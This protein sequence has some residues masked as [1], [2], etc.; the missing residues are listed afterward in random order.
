MTNSEKLDNVNFE[1]EF[2]AE[3]AEKK[4]EMLQKEWEA[5]YQ[6]ALE[7]ERNE[8]AEYV[9]NTDISSTRSRV[10]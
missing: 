1:K 5:N 10:K 7:N 9:G 8:H 4:L 6:F 2:K 3:C